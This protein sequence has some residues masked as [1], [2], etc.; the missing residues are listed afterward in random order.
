MQQHQWV[1]SAFDIRQSNVPGT[2][3]A[4]SDFLVPVGHV[5]GR[6][7]SVSAMTQWLGL[8]WRANATHQVLRVDAGSSTD[9]GR[10][11]PGTPQDL[12]SLRVSKAM[13]SIGVAAWLQP[14][15]VGKRPADDAGSLYAP[16]FV[17][18][19]MGAN[20]QRGNWYCNVAL[21]NALDKRYVQAISA[22]DTVRQGQRR[23]L[24]LG[25]RVGL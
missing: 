10:L 24:T 16:G 2:D 1:L 18:W 7:L 6:G 15:W 17:R 21:E 22:A 11:L 23:R 4:D 13:P 3:P 20:L 8:D 19:D 9:Q 5:R 14:F 12:G 25:M